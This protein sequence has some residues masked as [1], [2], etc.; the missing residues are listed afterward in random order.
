MTISVGFNNT[1][2]HAVSPFPVVYDS[3]A[4]KLEYFNNDSK[5]SVALAIP[6]APAAVTASSTVTLVSGTAVT[7]ANPVWA[8]YY[9]GITG[10][11]AG[12]VQVDLSPDD[13][14]TTHNI[15]PAA[16]GN[17][18]SS[19]TIPV[20]VPAGWSFKV[21]TAVATINAASVIVTETY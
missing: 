19:Q 20:R 9:V 5:A 17:A 11:A 3:V 2:L 14:V 4:G 7:N 6:T 13:F 15:V 10:G 21:T 12:T 18:V 8:T 16:A 1:P